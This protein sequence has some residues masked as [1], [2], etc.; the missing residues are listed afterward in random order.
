MSFSNDENQIQPMFFD[1]LSDEDKEKY[2]S[3][4]ET[5]SNSDK[6]YKK[7]KRIESLQE[8]L[9]M[10]Q[11]Y[12]MRNDSD[13]W[14]RCLVCGVCWMGQDIAINTRQ[15]RLLVDKC[16][17]SINGAL[18]KMGYSTA[19]IK[20]SIT[21]ALLTYIPFLKGNFVEQRQWTVRRKIQFSPMPPMRGN[22]YSP[23]NMYQFQ[24]PEPGT[25]YLPWNQ[26]QMSSDSL[27]SPETPQEREIKYVF[28]IQNLNN[29]ANSPAFHNNPNSPTFLNNA[30]ISN[31]LQN[32]ISGPSNTPAN[33]IQN[34]T[35]NNNLNNKESA[36]NVGNDEDNEEDLMFMPYNE[37]EVEDSQ[38]N[39]LTD[40]CCCCPLNWATDEGINDDCFTMG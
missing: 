40:P 39:F 3:I 16:K 36:E 13:D 30:N 26:N 33:L 6:R 15:L 18:S 37:K 38:Y 19:P 25:P 29:N 23:Y 20:S 7:N 14:K 5:I 27:T 22:M 34:N 10:I 9:D 1:L 11:K 24:T 17:S 21:A 31:N 28:G 2:L 12:C 4:R 32:P 8:S 35:N